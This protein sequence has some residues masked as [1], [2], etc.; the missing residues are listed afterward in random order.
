M[1]LE[2]IRAICDAVLPTAE[3][4]EL[5]LATRLIDPKEFVRRAE[6]MAE[7]VRAF[8][9]IAPLLCDAL[10]AADTMING[11]AANDPQAVRAYCEAWGRLEAARV[12]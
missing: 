4:F 6:E 1:T 12:D 5:E 3:F 8:A 11:F 2:E 10:E 7:A 9:R